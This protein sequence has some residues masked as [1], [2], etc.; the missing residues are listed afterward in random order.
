[1]M[2]SL[3]AQELIINPEDITAENILRALS[4][5]LSNDQSE[6]QKA[7]TFITACEKKFHYYE[8]LIDLIISQSD[9]EQLQAILC[10]KNSVTRNIKTTI[11]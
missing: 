6:I 8:V 3:T 7:Q 2:Q 11:K 9:Q 10:L 1:M 4:N 5:S